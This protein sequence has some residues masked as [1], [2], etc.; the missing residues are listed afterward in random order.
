M[1]NDI[2]DMSDSVSASPSAVFSLEPLG[3]GT[4]YME[5]LSSYVKRLAHYHRLRVVD[6]LTYCATQTDDDVMMATIHKF[7]RIDGICGSGQVWSHL[8]AR[9]TQR[10]DVLYLSMSYWSCLLNGYRLMKPYHAWCPLC[11]ATYEQEQTPIYTPLMWS[12]QAVDI[13][14]IHDVSLIETC[15]HCDRRFYSMTHN[16]MCGFC[17]Q[18]KHWLG[19]TNYIDESGSQ[20]EQSYQRVRAVGRLLALAPQVKDVSR[21]VIPQVIETVKQSNDVP[22]TH[23]KR[24]MGIS[25]SNLSDLKAGIRLANLNTFANLALCS[26]N[27]LWFTLTELDEFRPVKVEGKPKLPVVQNPQPYLK[28][29]LQSTERLPA[30]GTIARQCGYANAATLRKLYPLEYEPLRQ[31]VRAEQQQALQAILDGDEIL[32]VTEMA[33][34]YGYKQSFLFHFFPDL[35]REV[36]TVV[37]QRQLEQCREKLQEVI[38]GDIFPGVSVICNMLNVGSYYLWQHFPEELNQIAELRQQ[39]NR[40]Q[41]EQ[42][43]ALLQTSLVSDMFPPHSLSQLATELG[44]TPRFLKQNFPMLSQQILQRW[45][46][47]K[48]NQ[49]QAT[50]AQ[51]REIVFELHQ[52][53]IFPSVDRLHAE[54]STWMIH[55]NIYRDV[56]NQALVDCGYLVKPV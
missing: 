2:W 8:L 53:G 9:L 19:D 43:Q 34:R 32:G 6:F 37:H 3:I 30:L 26:D 16:A 15:P 20:D 28:Q 17:S 31:R 33:R 48:F 36:A 41:W 38:D 35:C 7:H 22:Y 24:D 27:I 44:R 54:I 42:A 29:L 12:L 47:Y 46:D 23:L 13:C 5:S 49:V 21:N 4:P 39:K 1:K 18:C 55:G 52:Q 14:L 51:I 40:R 25:T 50:C 56:Y 10:S 11:Y 45:R